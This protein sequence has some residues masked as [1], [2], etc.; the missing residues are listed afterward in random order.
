MVSITRGSHCGILAKA[1][2]VD[3][4]AGDRSPRDREVTVT[5]AQPHRTHVAGTILECSARVLNQGPW[6]TKA[7]TAPALSRGCELGRKAGGSFFDNQGHFIRHVSH[8]NSFLSATSHRLTPAV[9]W[10]L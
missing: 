7:D 2:G 3:G 1:A 6:R 5:D 8:I 10:G 4:R 9:V